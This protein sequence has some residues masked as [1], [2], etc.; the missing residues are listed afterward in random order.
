M[1]GNDNGGELDRN[2]LPIKNKSIADIFQVQRTPSRVPYDVLDTQYRD[3]NFDASEERFQFGIDQNQEAVRAGYQSSAE[4]W[5][6]AITQGV[7]EAALGTLEGIGYLADFE[8]HKNILQG[9]E[10]EYG[11]WFSDVMKKSK[12]YV[13]EEMVPV[14]RT[15]AAQ[16]GFA[17][18]DGSWWA[19][20][21]PSIA[22]A[23][24]LM[25][26]AMGAT[27]IA[28]Y[29]GKAARALGTSAGIA[30]KVDKASDIVNATNKLLY[31]RTAG[32][33]T[34]GI[35]QAVFSRYME[36]T[37]EASGTYDE[38]YQKA[39]AAGKDPQLAAKEAGEAASTA[40][41]NN[42]GNIVFDIG[43][44]MSLTKGLNATNRASKAFRKNLLQKTAGFAGNT[45]GEGIEE[46]FQFVVS[47]EAQRKA[48]M[49]NDY[50]G[51]KDITKRIGDYSSDAEFKT[52]VLL[53]MVG[54]GVFTGAGA[55]I[56]KIQ[57]KLAKNA[58]LDV[59]KQKAIDEGDLV[60]AHKI[61]D[62][63]FSSHAYQQA[64]EGKLQD[65][66]DTYKK[67]GESTDEELSSKWQ[68]T[69][70]Q[71]KDFRERNEDIQKDL[72]FY[73]EQYLE[74]SDDTR[75][76]P[77]LL[78]KELDLK[79]TKRAKDKLRQKLA[80]EESDARV[81]A[82]TQLT[83]QEF[84]KRKLEAQKAT[85]EANKMA[86]DTPEF[87]KMSYGQKFLDHIDKE[88]T[89][90]TKELEELKDVKSQKENPTSVD[91]KVTKVAAQ[92]A[93]NEL[94][95]E[96]ANIELVSLQTSEG[97][98]AVKKDDEELF[99]SRALG[100]INNDTS[101]D[102][103]NRIVASPTVSKEANAKLSKLAKEAE[104]NAPI[105]TED[106]IDADA[107]SRYSSTPLLHKELKEVAE[108]TGIDIS[109]VKDINS[110]L[111]QYRSNS[112]FRDAFNAYYSEMAAN[113]VKAQTDAMITPT[114]AINEKA[115]H[116]EYMDLM[117]QDETQSSTADR[118]IVQNHQYLM[119][120]RNGNTI[121]IFGKEG[122]PV[123]MSISSAIA[124]GYIN[125][126]EGKEGDVYILRDEDGDPIL[127]NTNVRT[128]VDG[129]REVDAPF[130]QDWE[131]DVLNDPNSNLY[132]QRIFFEIPLDDKYSPTEGEPADYITIIPFI[133][134]DGKKLR[135]GKIRGTSKTS[136]GSPNFDVIKELR[137][138]IYTEW[139]ASGQKEGSY[140]VEKDFGITLGG[141]TNGHFNIS[142]QKR[143]NLSNYDGP[144]YLGVINTLKGTPE[145][146]DNL[147][148]EQF[149]ID[150]SD[151]HQG[152]MEG[153]M[154]MGGKTVLHVQTASGKYVPIGLYTAK[155][156]EIGLA[157]KEVNA[158]V[159]EMFSNRTLKENMINSEASVAYIAN[160]NERLQ[161]YLSVQLTYM[162]DGTFQT[163]SLSGDES[164]ITTY[165]S[166]DEMKDIFSNLIMRIRHDRLNSP[167]KYKGGKTYNEYITENRWITTNLAVGQPTVLAAQAKLN[168]D[169]FKV[170]K[171]GKRVVESKTKEKAT[172]VKKEKPIVVKTEP[173][174][175]VVEETIIEDVISQVEYNQ[176]IDNG[177]V[178][179]ERIQSLAEK[180][181]I[182][183]QLSP[184]E[185]EMFTDKTK[186]INAILAKEVVTEDDISIPEDI[187]TNIGEEVNEEGAVDG[188]FFED[189]DFDTGRDTEEGGDVKMSRKAVKGDYKVW[190]REEELAWFKENYPNVPISVLDDLK[191]I[192]DNGGVEL[193][194]LFKNGSVYIAS[195]AKEGT[196]YHEAF[197]AVFHILLNENERGILLK[198][199][200]GKNP[201]D[202]EENMA[203]H[204]MEYKLTQGKMKTGLSAKVL[205]F[206]KKLY[207]LI[208]IA[209]ERIGIKGD[210]TI[211]DYMY[212]IDKGL[213]NP[214]K[215]KITFTK[216]ITR[217]SRTY[218]SE[219]LTPRGEAMAINT[220]NSVVIGKGIEIFRSH[221]QLS[222]NLSKGEAVREMLRVS[223]KGVLSVAG[224]KVLE[225]LYRREKK[226]PKET[227]VELATLREYDKQVRS[228][229]TI[230]GLYATA[231][232]IIQAD[233][234]K[235]G[236]KYSE[237]G[238]K[239]ITDVVSK[240][241]T[242]TSNGGYVFS[243][244][245]P[246][247]AQDLSVR[248]GLGI[249][250]DRIVSDEDVE[251]D[252]L[253]SD[254]G[255]LEGWQVDVFRDH[256][257]KFSERAKMAFATVQKDRDVAGYPIY[258]SPM[259][260]YA[261]LSNSLVDARN[262]S[263]MNDKLSK[264]A[265][266]FPS[267]QQV[268]QILE[269]DSKISVEMWRNMGNKRK[270]AF[271]GV[272]G[273][274]TYDA[275][276]NQS[277][278]TL[279]FIANRENLSKD[280]VES[281]KDSF[282]NS[283][284]FDGSTETSTVPQ[285]HLDT[286][287][288]LI[289]ET[290]KL[291]K[292]APLKEEHVET[293]FD[294]L[295]KINMPVLKDTL[296]K[297]FP[298]T[299]EGKKSFKTFIGKSGFEAVLTTMV[300]GKNPFY[301]KDS[302]FYA[303][304]DMSKTIANGK[305]DT[306]KPIFRSGDKQIMTNVDNRFMLDHMLNLTGPDRVAFIDAYM[307]TAFYKNSPIMEELKDLK[308]AEKTAI[309]Y[310]TSYDMEGQ[311]NPIEYANMS[312][313]QLEA[314]QINYWMNPKEDREDSWAYYMIPILSDSSNTAFMYW[315][316]ESSTII[317]EKL[318]QTAQQEKDRIEWLQK[319]VD[320]GDT[321]DIPYNLIKNGLKYQIFAGLNGKNLDGDNFRKEVENLLREH[322][323]LE[324]QKLFTD[325]ILTEV[326][327][328]NGIISYEDNTGMLGKNVL[329]GLKDGR[330]NDYLMNRMYMN[331]QT[332][333]LFGGDVAQY[334]SKDGNVD[335]VDV[336]KRIKQ[337]HSPQN[338][339]SVNTKNEFLLKN[340]KSVIVRPNYYVAYVTD[341][342]EVDKQKI[343]TEHKDLINKT[344]PGEENK[345]IRIAYG[346]EDDPKDPSKGGLNNT[347]A[348][349]VIDL[350]RMREIYLGTAKWTEE[351][352]EQYDE[353]ILG[354]PPKNPK[355]EMMNV[356][357]PFNYTHRFIT[358]ENGDVH[359]V[360]TQIKNSE[361]LLTP[362]MAK[363]NPKLQ[364][365]LEK[366]G[367]E[368]KKDG[369]VVFDENKRLVDAVIFGSA[370]KVGQFNRLDSIDDI[371][372]KTVH[373][374]ENSKYAIQQETP[375]HYRDSE[376]NVGTQ[377]RK[378]ITQDMDKSLTYNVGGKPMIGTEVF[379]QYQEAI[380]L[381][382]KES[383][384][385][386][387]KIFYKPDGTPD[388]NGIV[389]AL[390]KEVVERQMGED[391]LNALDWVDKNRTETK[392][393]LWD[394]H[395][396]YQVEAILSSY[397]KNNV[398]KQKA[399]GVSLFNAS[400][401]G[402]EKINAAG[403]R[404]PELVIAE[405]EN[406]NSYIKEVEVLMPAHARAMYDHYVGE[407]GY[408]DVSKVPDE[409]K[410]GVFYRIP[411]EGK[412]S[413]FHIKVIGYLEGVGGQIIMPD[414]V[415]TIAGLDFDIDK[416]F[417][418][419]YN[420]ENTKDGLVK[421]ESGMTTKE[422]RDNLILDIKYA[423]LSHSDTMKKQLTPGNY[424][425]LEEAKKE[426]LALEGNVAETLNMMLPST[427]R[428]IFNRNMTGAALIGQGANQNVHHALV[429]EG[430]FK[431]PKG[432]AFN[433]KVLKDLSDK[434]DI[435]KK[436]KSSS[437]AQFIAAYVDNAKDP[438][439]SF[440][441]ITTTT[442][443]LI[444]T[445]IRVGHD[446]NA[447]MLM[448]ASP[449]AKRFSKEL[450]KEG[451]SV[452]AIDKVLDTLMEE[453][454]QSIIKA[455]G[456]KALT[457]FEKSGTEVRVTKN[458]IVDTFKNPD[459]ID[460]LKT[461]F[462]IYQL[463]RSTFKQ[464]QALTKTMNGMRFDAVGKAAGPMYANIIVS[465]RTWR[466]A[467]A[468]DG[469]HI[470]GFN[471]F[472]ES[473]VV[474]F[475]E[476]FYK[477]GIEMPSNEV[478]E[479]VFVKPVVQTPT[480]SL[481]EG[482]PIFEYKGKTINTEFKLSSDQENAL[483]KLIDFTKS[484]EDRFVL[485]GAAGTGK[486]S[487]IGYLSKYLSSNMLY[488]APTHAATVELAVAT[489]KTGNTNLP[490]TV[491]SSMATNQKTGKAIL[492]KK[493]EEALGFSNYI[494]VDEVS[495]LQ[496]KD[497]QRLKEI[498]DLGY[499]IIFLG[500]KKQIPE[501]AATNPKEKSI[502]TAF[503]ENPSVNLDIIHRTSNNN[504]KNVLQ[505]VRDSKT[506][507][508]F[509]T[510]ENTEN[511]KF[512]DNRKDF[513]IQLRDAVTSDPEN[514]DF[515]GYTNNSV[516]EMNKLIRE[517]IFKRT[518]PPQVGDIVMGYLGYASKQIER[519]NLAN[520]VGFTIQNINKVE[521]DFYTGYQL[522]LR[523]ERLNDLREKGFRKVPE[524]SR[525]IYLPLNSEGAL[526]N[527][528]T[529]KELNLNNKY[530]SSQFAQLYSALE[531]AKRAKRWSGYYSAIDNLAQRLAKL[532]IDQD[533]IYN[534]KT[535]KMEKYDKSNPS[536]E[537]RTLYGSEKTKFILEK[538]IDYGHAI[539]IHKSQGRTTKNVF[540]DANTIIK[541]D[542]KILENGEQMSTERQS[543]GYV[544]MSRAS[545]N[546]HV[547]MG[548]I[549][550]TE[551]DNVSDEI[552]ETPQEVV[553]QPTVEE[554]QVDIYSQLGDKTA[555][556]N[557]V[558]K[559]WS[560]LKNMTNAFNAR[561]IISTRIP[562]TEEHF[563][564]PFSHAPTGKTQGLIKVETVK[565]AVEKYIDWVISS[566]DKR[567]NWIRE[568]IKSGTLKNKSIL[569]Y[570][571]L[572]EPS[573]ATALDYLI[574]KYDWNSTQEAPVTQESQGEFIE[575]TT[576]GKNII[577]DIADLPYEK[578]I[579]DKIV[580]RFA[581]Y[582][583][584]G[585][586]DAEEINSIYRYI[587]TAFV[588]GYKTF[589]HTDFNMMIGEESYIKV[590]GKPFSEVERVITTTPKR[591]SK[592]RNA[593]P[594]SPY[595]VIL[596]QFQTRTD[597]NS[598][599]KKD[600][601]PFKYI[602][603][604]R[605]GL[606]EIHMEAIKN[607]WK[608]MIYS[609]VKE[610]RILGVDLAKYA[611]FSSGHTFNYN[612]FTDLVP[613]DFMFTL[614]NTN[615]DYSYREYQKGSE[616]MKPMFDRIT[617][618]HEMEGL[619]EQ[620]VR[621][622]Y[623]KLKSVPF[624]DARENKEISTRQLDGEFHLAVPSKFVNMASNDPITG[625]QGEIVK[626]IKSPIKQ[627]KRTATVLL[628]YVK[629]DGANNALYKVLPPLGINNQFIEFD[630][631]RLTHQIQSIYKY[632]KVL[633]PE[634]IVKP[635]APIINKN[636]TITPEDRKKTLRVVADMLGR[637]SNP[638]TSSF[639][640]SMYGSII[641]SAL[642][643][644]ELTIDA[645]AGIQKEA[646][647]FT[648]NEEFKDLIEVKPNEAEEIVKRCKGV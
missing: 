260:V 80:K 65:T 282:Y 416:L 589:Q 449:A 252:E 115:A 102:L 222:K 339:I 247:A 609:E 333:Y 543:L 151:V 50:E 214:F 595:N 373:R 221:L 554:Q 169:E 125:V 184:R 158:I 189:D 579:F 564:N 136:K 584:N 264:V 573:H 77:T 470:T 476:S 266:M 265:E 224:R 101:V 369:T 576:Q 73:Q 298:E 412:Y 557:V 144:L 394:A 590:K 611:F 163:I 291:D 368:F 425:L 76:D 381:N 477:Y 251:H 580:E 275:E 495:M 278:K 217:F 274:K 107:A 423:I 164:S 350:F 474:P 600:R 320:K 135:L 395:I 301:G 161:E 20:N 288:V 363:G 100:A 502:S 267:Y 174:E 546:L 182:G 290:N 198:E 487:I 143:N 68:M 390:R 191:K 177:V 219:G 156:R 113:A 585:E 444:A 356:V 404:K 98:A 193:W 90:V 629:N 47:K 153:F 114:E 324:K 321:K 371:N 126:E 85:L 604:N 445:M 529:D 133:E 464:T 296:Y 262:E 618:P 325:D 571:E 625:K 365:V 268:I 172:V 13:N 175:P 527:D 84:N 88:I 623:R 106:S 3:T 226:L 60:T 56:N 202:K 293:L 415:T 355:G 533:M 6:K 180:V 26:P 280:I 131:F 511:L 286:L 484:N 563:G 48:E 591:L 179:K 592:Y 62:A 492:S 349:T 142:N 644:Q 566:Q 522:N 41:K 610:E 87:K 255:I 211:D 120:A 379:R 635:A 515:I 213:Y 204:F 137:N 497:Y 621:N 586:L 467:K 389:T 215:Q 603:F 620:I 569:Y 342:T 236:A 295:K 53:G 86:H 481:E 518:G 461:N 619:F 424:K 270:V 430:D 283:P 519:G 71:I 574:N 360:P 139:S 443:D 593:N 208:Q 352:Q 269:D 152:G 315:K 572:G 240:F 162:T 614:H 486:T 622:G 281:W 598:N 642:K 63:Q 458:T 243:S 246:R 118:A 347:D 358:G 638:N 183:E 271:I 536:N 354:K 431:L 535:N 639:D 310:F 64:S 22:S 12:E 206:F 637:L 207:H 216:D 531:E 229:F 426:V 297:V 168:L 473:G 336:Y 233:F 188:F 134:Y 225:D 419:M 35:T 489:M 15:E 503:T 521:T 636:E 40:W 447:V 39:I 615:L 210:A 309:A 553:E 299:I 454:R 385:E 465:K 446:P 442:S 491:A 428:E 418:M 402:Y 140:I 254:E 277:I 440:L 384:D 157:T 520:S 493:A 530:L 616:R 406:G 612:S 451:K 488:L 249:S 241:A 223:K 456:T 67:M 166:A 212:R 433:G 641:K 74:I 633:T 421:I 370:V 234:K 59:A 345:W 205:S 322:L 382:I 346:V 19:F 300:D 8:Q 463:M 561:G 195:H 317:L 555:T 160:V 186:E 455:E 335:F 613:M 562:N 551:I 307:R 70:E 287:K 420:F 509:K 332:M 18:S 583:R 409:L 548:W 632:I 272:T 327:D 471:K 303:L 28:S 588:T 399:Y 203:D 627:G 25:I 237:D 124:E 31:G 138:Q 242:Q 628:K 99:K 170:G 361:A 386:L 92:E 149:G 606:D 374:M 524:V 110:F 150:R 607:A 626:Y 498:G 116:E 311:D 220:I 232:Q 601:I 417:G 400:S 33:V 516:S 340:G 148:A 500:D 276:G 407:D 319:R 121:T 130:L 453:V 541:S 392:L 532:D 29:L 109:K 504:I 526:E 7:S 396:V 507:K 475:V 582:K 97:Q 343:R 132:G 485:Q 42:W 199:F 330:L 528:L 176:F 391:M 258:E 96:L 366:M 552:V 472:I 490:M 244:I 587:M 624:L 93:R 640:A 602:A 510:K 119:F 17:P 128:I 197:H 575:K 568:E 284:M 648:D 111:T 357:K 273:E 173:I 434:F 9:T 279:S 34:E 393:P 570:K 103:I 329:D 306:Y 560:D 547:N 326:K 200:K 469:E 544:G 376:N 482:K 196:V 155:L 537:H 517:R 387:K 235:N 617:D 192:S 427:Q 341:P 194:G 231:Y 55:G 405:D 523:S 1:F 545:E 79:F 218:S 94:E 514:T 506:F 16:Q 201:I 187:V 645:I 24:S 499:K 377:D 401:Y 145:I 308:A 46:G 89:R 43:Q 2:N 577:L 414:E 167:E 159:D 95:M 14:Y 539:T 302:K 344:F 154:G 460:T 413:M 54:G 359:V 538:G 462:S 549:D 513:L 4:L 605:N 190:N 27:K 108:K 631:N 165:R 594:D 441:N 599:K 508:L 263:E 58:Q 496:Q 304:R 364:K 512:Y 72:A 466:D 437:L 52:S 596:E 438:M 21:A 228:R 36:N 348:A 450:A 540:F 410:M 550:F 209:A 334:K 117:P 45:V 436:F 534:H 435:F 505:N 37:M 305:E 439:A 375:E 285:E 112:K 66:I 608:R 129:D 480:K 468:A 91:S 292:N 422:S 337:I 61:N 83:P 646:E 525:T 313:Q 643:I 38:Y 501:V 227:V 630:L 323:K 634:K 432:I 559:P 397:F 253:A 353:M 181:K 5:G 178:A 542:I 123:K 69:P 429:T 250:I 483:K 578:P 30:S 383:F 452:V 256:Y 378:L 408:L 398:T 362:R 81:E 10:T 245:L 411:T 248:F 647:G 261:K 565:E 597:E 478:T 146:L 257:S 380:N 457:A 556:G 316:K 372:N 127:S 494:V 314:L 75:K 448:V 289:T 388:L 11:N 479:K 239:Y 318:I 122:R 57:E 459:S 351:L 581:L 104:K 82:G 294:I 567:A 105:P 32:Q 367:Y 558:I 238:A 141:R 171:K 185:V 403:L 331:I 44:Y 259:K 51:W 78:K 230:Q 49:G 338:H 147:G 23:V 328:E 312:P